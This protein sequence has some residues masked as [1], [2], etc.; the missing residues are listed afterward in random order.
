MVLS[1]EVGEANR[2][3]PEPWIL[4]VE[5]EIIRIVTW[6]VEPSDGQKVRASAVPRDAG[7]D[8]KAHQDFCPDLQCRGRPDHH[9]I[10]GPGELQGL[11]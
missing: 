6:L 10:E 3:T 2:R 1:R 8:R 5:K 11:V 4:K 9:R 7:T